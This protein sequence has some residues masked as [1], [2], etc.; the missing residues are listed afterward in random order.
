MGRSTKIWLG[1]AAILVAA[2]IVLFAVVLWEANF[3]INKLSTDTYVTNIYEISQ[4]FSSL[5]LDTDT[6]VLR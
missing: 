5:S 4:D 6:A 1:F 3:D 2:G